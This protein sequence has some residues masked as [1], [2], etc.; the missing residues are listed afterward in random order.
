MHLRTSIALVLFASAAVA[1][2]NEREVV[3]GTSGTQ[4]SASVGVGTGGEG[5]GTGGATT[6]GTGGEASSSDAT[7]DAASTADAT[8]TA[9]GDGGNGGA[10][11]TGGAGGAG[12][13]GE[14]GGF[15]AT[16]SNLIQDGTESAIDCGGD[17]CPRCAPGVGCAVG[18]DC[19]SGVCGDDLLCAEPTCAD[20]LTNGDESDVDC[21]GDTCLPCI[22]GEGCVLDD[23]CDS[24]VCSDAL[25]CA[26]PG[27]S[28]DVANG[29]ETDVD[30]GGSCPATCPDGA[31][32]NDDDECDSRICL[33]DDTCAVPTCSD[34]VSNGAETDIDCGGAQCN[35]C[36]AGKQCNGAGDCASNICTGGTCR[37]PSGMTTVPIA[38]GGSYCIDPTEV[39]NEEYI[40]FFTANP[41]STTPG[42]GFNV[43]GYTPTSM[44]PPSADS[45]ASNYVK[46]PVRFVDWCDA[47]MYCQYRG[48]RLCGAMEGGPVQPADLDDSNVDQWFNACTALGTNDYPYGSDTFDT[49]ACTE[50]NGVATLVP[51]AVR[52]PQNQVSASCQGGVSGVYQM[53]G[54][55]AEW[56][57]SCDGSTGAADNCVA[58]GGSYESTIDTTLRCDA[59][60]TFTRNT[61]AADIGIRCCQ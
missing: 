60:E 2:T 55:L 5:G 3:P 24:G 45:S 34:G 35:D 39:T 56:Q 8:S 13:G 54:N 59:I 43:G 1:C 28:D 53:S 48:K 32:C 52:N 18:T 31:R 27:C 23:D 26:A 4:V 47:A 22:P 49:G 16:C 36:G 7:T 30:C 11:G 51:I 33:V 15:P 6:A 17:E 42:C 40:D 41:D 61:T 12:N 57:D 50:S 21:G 46:R 58:R 10:P 20:G 38:L 14:G 37:C 29:D 44:W 9:S 19:D 25:V